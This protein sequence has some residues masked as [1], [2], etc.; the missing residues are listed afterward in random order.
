[1]SAKGLSSVLSALCEIYSTSVKHTFPWISTL[2]EFGAG[3]NERR[4]LDQ[5][6]RCNA[7]L[8]TNLIQL[9]ADVRGG[10]NKCTL[11]S[12]S[13]MHCIFAMNRHVFD[14]LIANGA[15]VDFKDSEGCS[16]LMELIQTP[17]GCD[18][19]EIKVK[20]G[21]LISNGAS[22]SAVNNN[23]EGLFDTERGKTEPY[24]GIIS[25]RV[26]H[27]NWQRRKGIVMFRDALYRSRAQPVVGVNRL[28]ALVTGLVATGGDGVFRLL[29][30]YI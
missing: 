4:V 18:E 2:V 28:S 7:D 1:M 23:G 11:Q 25:E 16:P 6:S 26:R 17:R 20:F 30:A 13:P 29:V 15:E 12:T 9:G 27:E 10:W 21:W 5:C 3:V 14:I 24:R 8:V 19:D 22:C